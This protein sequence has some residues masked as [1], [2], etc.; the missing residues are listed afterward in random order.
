MR[1]FF[2]LPARG[3]RRVCAGGGVCTTNPREDEA[4]RKDRTCPTRM[5]ASTMP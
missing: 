2:Y 4:N 3:A 1:T 5:I